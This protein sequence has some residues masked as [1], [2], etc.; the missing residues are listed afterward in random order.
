MQM[1]LT[2][3]AGRNVHG[4]GLFAVGAGSRR[5][6]RGDRHAMGGV[7]FR[8]P[9]R[10]RMTVARDACCACTGPDG[11]PGL[12]GLSRRPRLLGFGLAGVLAAAPAAALGLGPGGL[13]FGCLSRLGY[14]P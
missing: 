3:V 6:A 9:A 7:G 14:V 4:S 1:T 12:F 10:A 8:V 11:L 5:A 13:G 2:P